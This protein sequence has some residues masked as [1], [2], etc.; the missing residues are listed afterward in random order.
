[1]FAT[2]HQGIP[3]RVGFFQGCFDLLNRSLAGGFGGIARRRFNLDAGRPL[4]ELPVCQCWYSRQNE[5]ADGGP[6]SRKA[7]NVRFHG[8]RALAYR[9]TTTVVPTPTRAYRSIISALCMRMHPCDTNPPTEL[10]LL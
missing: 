8:F 5:G 9:K 2:S 10:G 1:F 4:H 3:V 7:N 6:N